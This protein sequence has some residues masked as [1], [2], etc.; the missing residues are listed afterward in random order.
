MT[1]GVHCLCMSM[2][3]IRFAHDPS[4]AATL[5]AR[6]DAYFDNNRIA[7]TANGAMVLKTVLLLSSAATLY[8]VLVM[9]HLPWWAAFPVCVAL[10]VSM[11]LIGFSVGHDAIHGSYSDKAW[12]NAALSRV[13]DVSGASSFTWSTAHN[14]VHHTYTNVPGVDDDLEPGP[15]LLFYPREN[16]HWVFRYQHIY[17]F[18]LY[19]FTYVTWVVKKDFV[20]LRQPDPRSDR[21]ASMGTV[22]S[23]VLW[24]IIHAGVFIIVPL[25]ISGYS[26]PAVLLGYLVTLMATGFT[27]AVVFQLAHCLEE[28]AF[29]VV[30]QP[31]S[32]PHLDDGFHAHQ[33]KTTCNFAASS[34][35]WQF[36]S[37]GLNQ[38]IEHHLFSKICH[39]HYPAL[40]P[41]VRATAAEFGLPYHEHRR[42]R[43]ALA[44]HVR[45]MKRFGLPT[46]PTAAAVVP[47]AMAAE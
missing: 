21:R 7:K 5:R 15:L 27:L 42:F 3:Q 28:V 11:A 24:K 13:F 2:A 17:A 9:A 39:I 46:P 25:A 8:A 23:V 31:L 19:A 41:I 14:F 29:P 16:P 34:P 36:V 43:D 37:G 47:M 4:F 6:V 22:V 26:W 32:N 44:S 35:F 1:M 33:L 12:V 40:M 18:V 38:Q 10:G 20:Q 30:Q 45:A